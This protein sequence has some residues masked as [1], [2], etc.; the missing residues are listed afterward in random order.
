MNMRKT[1]RGGI[2]I[3]AALVALGLGVAMADTNAPA[4]SR[5]APKPGDPAP[6]LVL[7]D[8]PGE[9]V[10]ISDL[11]YPGAEDPKKPRSAVVLNF[12]AIDCVPCKRELPLFLKTAREYKDKGVKF[13][14]VMT[15]PLSKLE[16]VKA[17]AK[18]HQIDCGVL[19]DPY[20]VAHDRLGISGTPAL[21][22]LTPDGTLSVMIQGAR[23]DY[24]KELRQA[25]E[26]AV[27]K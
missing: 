12:A 19:L 23:E 27:K 18:E 11:C 20:K 14:V 13:Y 1:R 21:A 2:G 17:F 8:L 15:D 26:K 7:R 5:P 24:E 4:T 6:P 22:V 16:A 9:F 25:V 3:V 10:I